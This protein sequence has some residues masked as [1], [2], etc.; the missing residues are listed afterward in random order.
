MENSKPTSI[1]VDLTVAGC[2][3]AQHSRT[4][5]NPK[6]QLESTRLILQADNVDMAQLCQLALMFRGGLTS[7]EVAKKASMEL[8][9]AMEQLYYIIQVI[10]PATGWSTCIALLHGSRVFQDYLGGGIKS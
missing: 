10:L 2:G 1:L 5:S 6:K 4:N 9:S 3:L 8:I 7:K